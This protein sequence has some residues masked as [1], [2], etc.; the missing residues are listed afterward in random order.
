MKGIIRNSMNIINAYNK[1]DLTQ[2]TTA[3]G[4]SITQVTTKIFKLPPVVNLI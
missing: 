3:V 2:Q 1:N 4:I